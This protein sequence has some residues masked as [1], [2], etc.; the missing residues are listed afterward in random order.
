MAACNGSPE[1][2]RE[3]AAAWRL[4]PEPPESAEVNDPELFRKFLI[5]LAA[6]CD[7]F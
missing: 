3:T 4:D 7:S 1:H 5:G 6:D 2:S